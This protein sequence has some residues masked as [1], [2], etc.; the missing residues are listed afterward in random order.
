MSTIQLENYYPLIYKI[1]N[2]FDSK[3]KEELF[4]ECYIQLEAIK[5]RSTLI[6]TSFE[7]YA[8]KRLYFTCIDFIKR[9]ENEETSLDNFI[10]IEDSD[11]RFS[12][13]IEDEFQLD[14][15]ITKTDYINQHNKQLSP[16]ELFIQKK[17]Y[18]DNMSVR[19]L[20]K[21]YQP[22]HLIKSEQTIRKILKY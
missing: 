22:Y 4:N 15:Y 1:I 10:S 12:D 2:K 3:Y 19:N 13:L 16:T 7:T 11:S 20:I 8:Y 9:F 17:Y 18:Q 21:V 14:D 5:E 6:K